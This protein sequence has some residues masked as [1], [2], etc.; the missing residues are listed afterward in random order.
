MTGA[1]C[2]FPRGPL[3]GG[4]GRRFIAASAAQRA[5]TIHAKIEYRTAPDEFRKWRIQLHYEALTG[6]NKTAYA[7]LLRTA[8]CG[9]CEVAKSKCKYN[10]MTSPDPFKIFQEHTGY[11]APADAAAGA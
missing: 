11:V 4:V 1:E 7:L 9:M 8:S 5:I 3:A 10:E 6:R 2:H